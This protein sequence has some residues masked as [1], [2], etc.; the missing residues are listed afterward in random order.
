[1]KTTA[2]GISL[3]LGLV[4]LYVLVYQSLHTVVHHQYVED[5]DHCCIHHIHQNNDDS[6]I[7]IP[8][9]SDMESDCGV[10]DF[11]FACFRLEQYIIVQ[12]LRVIYERPILLKHTN[13][14]KSN[15]QSVHFLRGPPHMLSI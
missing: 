15:Y 7:R 1:M 13:W 8:L 12:T 14:T 3:L 9:Y 4:I 10:C 11:E 5:V 6:A 2:K